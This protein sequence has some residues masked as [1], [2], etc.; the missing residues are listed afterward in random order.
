MKVAQELIKALYAIRNA[1]NG[2]G[3]ENNI[4]G[5][6]DLYG[7]KVIKISQGYSI[8]EDY[9]TTIKLYAK[10]I[11]D[12]PNFVDR[13][14]NG[15]L[16]ITDVFDGDV[17]RFVNFLTN[18]IKNRQDDGYHT[19]IYFDNNYEEFFQLHEGYEN[20]DYTVFRSNNYFYSNG[21]TNYIKGISNCEI[22]LGYRSIM[23][24]FTYVN[25]NYNFSTCGWYVNLDNDDNDT[26]I[27]DLL[28][29]PIR[30]TTT[31]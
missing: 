22:N 30:A 9:A 25:S 21:R 16:L 4:E 10:N 3:K 11:S 14:E 6:I 12:I 2:N 23:I 1:I 18:L 24:N 27:D 28:T 17:V 19:V 8:R 20:G 7:E 26:N 29:T 13:F 31:D 15:Q 5:L